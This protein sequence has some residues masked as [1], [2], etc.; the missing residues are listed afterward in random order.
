MIQLNGHYEG[1]A[2]GETF[3]GIDKTDIIIKEQGHNKFI[4]ECKFWAGEEVL[5]HTVDQILNYTSRRDTKTAILIF[6]RN[7]DFSNVLQQIPT[8]MKNHS[9]FKGDIEKTSETSFQ[10]KFRNKHDSEKEL[11]LSILAFHILK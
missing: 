11:L 7:K 6:V 8:T 9:Q 5:N 10:S 3:N 4:G 2:T 1:R